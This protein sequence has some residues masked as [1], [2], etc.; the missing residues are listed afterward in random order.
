MSP[1][2]RTIARHM[3][4]SVRISPHATA[5]AE[6]TMTAAAARIAASK[7]SP[8]EWKDGPLTYTVLG[9]RAAVAALADFPALNASVVGEE[10]VH[11]PHVN[12][13]V[14]VA[15]PDTDDLIVPVV[16]RAE[17]LSLYGLA[18]A[19]AD[20]AARARARTLRPSD[21][22][23]GTFTLTNPG[24]F[25]GLTGTPILNQ[26][27]VAILGLGAVVKKPVAIDDEAI[28][29]RPV[30][31]MALTFDHRAADGMMAFRYLDRVRQLLES[32]ATL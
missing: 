19:V 12:L 9:A 2:R 13:G 10:I 30:M 18:R 31:T 20:L 32:A 4:W 7:A 26:P 28:A 8:D 3:S 24:M 6:C 5:F 22:Q 1:V 25:G 16:P 14:A 11:R 23:G 17:E 29:V 27:Q 21:V 15:L